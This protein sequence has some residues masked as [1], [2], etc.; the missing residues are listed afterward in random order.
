M[1][2]HSRAAVAATLAALL[3]HVSSASAER[4]DVWE[5]AKDPQVALEHLALRE[6]QRS[7]VQAR[8]IGILSPSGARMLARAKRV[9]EKAGA[10]DAR[11]PRVKVF[12]GRVLE[13][14]GDDRGAVAVLESA[15]RAAPSHP[16]IPDAY[17]ALAVSYARLGRPRDEVLAY[18]SFLRVETSL[19]Q[20]AIAL[21]NQAEGH[22]VLGDLT[23]SIRTY[24]S[25]IDLAHDNAL[26]HWGLAV[27]LDR[28]GE[29]AGA[30]A[31]AGI[32][33]TYDRDARQLNGTGVFFVP[34][35]DRFWYR[36]LG[37]MSR[38]ATADDPSS[39]LPWWE[40]ANLLWQQYVDAAPVDDRWLPIAKSRR[41]RCEVGERDARAAS[42]RTRSPKP[43]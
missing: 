10:A 36:A 1:A 22:M 24:R 6:A 27:A 12:Y 7:F 39:A 16:D 38:A 14:L 3:L 31:E 28:W 37:A 35:Y 15:V 11:D 30:L 29:H 13:L 25:A 40:R 23:R 34:A 26:A 43:R 19:E 42:R 32:A 2:A 41:A 17:F 21:S 18:D 33:L 8:A 9:L 20:R 4:P 5:V